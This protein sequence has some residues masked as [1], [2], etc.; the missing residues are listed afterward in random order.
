M[1]TPSVLVTARSASGVSVSVSVSLSL[2]AFG[3]PAKL[4]VA[5]LTSEPVAEAAM[6]QVAV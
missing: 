2:A 4:T 3:S 1:A 5:V 6:V